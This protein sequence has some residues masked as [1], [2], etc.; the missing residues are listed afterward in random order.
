MTFWPRA[1]VT[2]G[3]RAR[4]AVGEKEADDGAKVGAGV[5]AVLAG[6]DERWKRETSAPVVS[7][8]VAIH[9]SRGYLQ[10]HALIGLRVAAVWHLHLTCGDLS[11]EFHFVVG[12]RAERERE[13]SNRLRDRDLL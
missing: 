3:P 1:I 12:D 2:T 10:Q 6:T 13:R 4:A 7:V 8:R 11:L 9:R 5:E